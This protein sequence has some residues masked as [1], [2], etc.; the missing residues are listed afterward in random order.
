MQ[1]LSTETDFLYCTT[2]T[3][4]VEQLNQL[5][6]EVGSERTLLVLCSAFRG[7][8][9][10]MAESDGEENSSCCSAQ[11]RMG[12]RRLFAQG[13]KPAKASEEAANQLVR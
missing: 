10:S 11:M 4:S 9:G 1:G 7:G 8:C 3:L 6:E 5:S 12:P 2:Q 13:G